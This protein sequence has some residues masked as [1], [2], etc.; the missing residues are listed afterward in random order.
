MYV[1]LVAVCFAVSLRYW[2]AIV[3]FGIGVTLEALFSKK[4]EP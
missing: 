1:G 4:S 2:P 3:G